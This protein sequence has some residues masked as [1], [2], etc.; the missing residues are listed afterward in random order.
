MLAQRDDSH[1][2]VYKSRRCFLWENDY[3]QMDIYKTPCHPRCE[4]MILLETY[5]TASGAELLNKLPPFL[6]I[7][8][9]VTNDPSFSMYN[10]SCKTGWINKVKKSA[11]NGSSS[12]NGSSDVV[13][14]NNS[15]G[16]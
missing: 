7:Q 3:Y 5:T 9:E 16:H 1:W 13:T 12:A 2:T 14:F 4:G 15:V 6:D 8:R 11:P 10:L